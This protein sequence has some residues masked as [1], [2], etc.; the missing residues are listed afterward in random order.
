MST[1]ESP[2][3]VSRGLLIL[4]GVVVGLAGLYAL[5]TFVIAPLLAE[6]DAVDPP[7]AT[8]D[9]D[10]PDD[11]D[12]APSPGE[13]DDPFDPDDPD[14]TPDPDDPDSL[15]EED[16]LPETFEIF[17]ARDPFQQLVV[18][19]PVAVTP[20]A[21][22]PGTPGAPAPGT[23][24]APAP[25]TPGAPAPGTP[26]AP[27]PGT[28]VAPSPRPTTPGDMNGGGGMGPDGTGG[29]GEDAPSSAEVGDTRVS[30]TDVFIDE[31]GEPRVLV[32]VNG[33]THEVGEGE[34]FAGRFQ[35]LD[36]DGVCATF[37]FGDSRF[38][39]CEGESIIK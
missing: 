33:R 16:V 3:Q 35:V 23:P 17:S 31:D 25:G 8:G 20:T 11:P 18:E 34:V 28:P 38:T 12:E 9:P 7:V 22:A 37:L 39:L 30:L 5:Y 29:G 4:L 26:G 32:T 10:D 14:A 27:A 15:V 1:E 13:P 36:I 19:A 24:G 21:P 2:Q 6:D